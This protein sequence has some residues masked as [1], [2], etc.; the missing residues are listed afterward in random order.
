MNAAKRL[1]AAVLAITVGALS[2]PAA[3]VAGPATS[4]SAEATRLVDDA[5]AIAVG[6]ERDDVRFTSVESGTASAQTAL[7]NVRIPTDATGAIALET[8]GLNIGIHLPVSRDASESQLADGDV[9]VEDED[10]SFV[11]DALADGVRIASV[12]ESAE[13][14]H[15]L[16]YRF[17]LPGGMSPQLNTDGSV[18]LVVASDE[19]SKVTS[20]HFAPPWAVDAAG[21]RVDTRYEVDGGALT[22]VV[23]PGSDTV[24]PV[25]ADPRVSGCL[26]GGW[27]PALCI[28]YNRAETERAYNSI[29][30]GIGAAAFAAEMCSSLGNIVQKAAC[31]AA[32]AAIFAL[33]INDVRLAHDRRKCLQ[34]R[35]S[36]P[37]IA[38]VL[39]ASEVVNC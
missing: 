14:D 5:V 25:V 38:S 1:P 37:P 34:I 2:L 28:T 18:S 26:I 35:W 15:S 10:T 12:I 36:Y 30:G 3:A 29:V 32:V 19:G 33:V 4:G 7:G 8:G 11:V 23:T 22:Q 13:A 21:K 20:A 16:T 6:E 17:E 31:K 27:Y 39:G 9:V 24:Y